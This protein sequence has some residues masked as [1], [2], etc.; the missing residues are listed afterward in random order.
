MPEPPYSPK[1]RKE[2]WKHVSEIQS[3]LG[4]EAEREANRDGDEIVMVR[5]VKS[6][7]DNIRIR[8]TPSLLL[9]ASQ[10]FGSILFGA[11]LSQ[12][13]EEILDDSYQLEFLTLILV[14]L[15]LALWLFG[16]LRR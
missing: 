14:T 5:H 6:A 9:D 1:A 12:V 11:G 3:E 4:R 15:G 7:R 8:S 16:Y 13:V 10:S 2:F